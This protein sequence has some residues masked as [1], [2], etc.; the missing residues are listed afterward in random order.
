MLRNERPMQNKPAYIG[1]GTKKLSEQRASTNQCN[2]ALKGR[3]WNTAF[4][5]S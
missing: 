4:L 5:I 1:R 2:S 3:D